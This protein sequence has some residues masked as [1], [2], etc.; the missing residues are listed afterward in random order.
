MFGRIQ[1]RMGKEGNLNRP[2]PPLHEAEKDPIKCEICGVKFSLKSRVNIHIASV[3]ER[4][5]LFTCEICDYSCSQKD[6]MKQ[7]V[8]TVHQKKKQ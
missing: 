2:I 7:H 5:K 4:K 1:K 6:V 8:A 3:H